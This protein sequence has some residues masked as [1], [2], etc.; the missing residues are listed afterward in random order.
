MSYIQDVETL[1]IEPV[2]NECIQSFYNMF[3]I[4]DY[5]IL[6]RQKSI[7]LAHKGQISEIKYINQRLHEPTMLL[8]SLSLSNNSAT[9]H[10]TNIIDTIINPFLYQ[11]QEE[12]QI[13]REQD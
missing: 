10:S 11:L 7:E 8:R 5:I 1:A 3:Y 6:L 9:N 2:I 4:K 12:L 13:M